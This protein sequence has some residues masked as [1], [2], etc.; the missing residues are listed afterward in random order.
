VK[1][2]HKV[3]VA[4]RKNNR[5][6]PAFCSADH[7]REHEP[8]YLSWDSQT[9]SKGFWVGINNIKTFTAKYL[10]IATDGNQSIAT[11]V[12]KFIG[13]IEYLDSVL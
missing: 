13:E 5:L 7:Q 1:L 2:P 10:K 6:S 8:E 12:N 3:D 9:E 11:T 4:K